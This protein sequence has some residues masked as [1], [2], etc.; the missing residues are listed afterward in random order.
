MIFN[1]LKNIPKFLGK[2][3]EITDGKL[4]GCESKLHLLRI[5]EAPKLL[6]LIK[7]TYVIIIFPVSKIPDLDFLDRFPSV[8]HKKHKD[9]SKLNV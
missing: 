3:F 9:H 2:Y 1:S 8:S 4:T 5:F 7:R 6:V